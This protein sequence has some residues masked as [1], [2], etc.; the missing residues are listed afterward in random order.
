M[1]LQGDVGRMAG[2]MTDDRSDSGGSGR[3]ETERLVLRRPRADD[4]ETIFARYASDPEVTRYLSF[5]RHESI[6]QTR[7]FLDFSADEWRRWPVGPYLIE[8]RIDGRLL[9]GTGLAFESPWCAST[10]YLLAREAWGQGYATEAVGAMVD[11]ARR[12]GVI[13][14]YAMCHVDHGASRRVLEKA[15]FAHEGVLCR[16][17]LFPNLDRPGPH[18]AHCYARILA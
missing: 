10:G 11:V 14:L 3:I 2:P 12:A 4:A 13:R 15:G 7:A 1:E 6:Q 16:S 17:T 18:D 5:P 8:H 9:G